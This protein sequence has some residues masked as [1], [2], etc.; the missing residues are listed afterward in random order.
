[1]AKAK[2]VRQP[3]VLQVELTA[4]GWTLKEDGKSHGL[5]VS[6]DKAVSQLKERQ[7]ALKADGRPSKL[8]ITGQE[9]PPQSKWRIR[10]A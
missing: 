5:F 1:M 2:K 8:V 10:I 3:V 4:Y 7:K 6:K 9:D